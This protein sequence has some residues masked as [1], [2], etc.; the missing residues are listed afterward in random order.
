MTGLRHAIEQQ[1]LE[2]FRKD[3][4]NRRGQMPPSVP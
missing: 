1:G 2:D 4:Y 3:F